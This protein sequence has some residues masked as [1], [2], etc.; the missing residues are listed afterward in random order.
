MTVPRNSGIDNPRRRDTSWYRNASPGDWATVADGDV[1]RS[2][3]ATD[4]LVGTSS[5][6]NMNR[7]DTFD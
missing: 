7:Q 5:G 1:G 2:T 4:V 3:G 6:D